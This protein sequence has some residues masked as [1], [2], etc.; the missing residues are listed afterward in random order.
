MP[1]EELIRST[2]ARFGVDTNLALSVARAES[3][4]NQ[5]AISPAGAIGV[6]QL[7]PPTAADLGVNPYNLVE[8]IEGGV[9][10]LSQMLRQFGGDVSK[11]LAAY[12]W[13][14]GN[15]G[16]A[17]SRYGE[18][19]LAHAPAETRAYVPKILGFVGTTVAGVT[20]PEGAKN[21]LLIAAAV[22][23]G[24]ALLLLSD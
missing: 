17:I 4:F 12:N 6:F 5:S 21:T 9:R 8:N 11:A 20:K 22:T 7:M 19:Y 14:P 18:N 15:L 13:G 23:L 2:A 3:N 24:A 10:Y 1:I 16:R